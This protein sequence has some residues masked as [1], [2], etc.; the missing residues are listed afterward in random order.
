MQQRLAGLVRQEDVGQTVRRIAGLDCGY[1]GNTCV[2]GAVVW[3]I[4]L[5]RS[6]EEA[7]AEVEVDFPYVPGLLSF[8]ELPGLM[9]AYNKL[10]TPVDLLICDGQ[11]YAHPRRFGLACHLGVLLGIPTVGCA[12]RALVG[13]YEPPGAKRGV[14]SLI[15]DGSE[16]L[17]AAVRTRTGVRPVFISVGHLVTLDTACTVVLRCAP[18]YR[19]PEPTRRAD[20]LVSRVR[21]AS[22]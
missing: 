1:R 2:A 19:V 22:T 17:G 4:E 6:V 5:E 8:R 13:R 20:R 12:K 14:R 16:L 15:R 7:T 3:D 10:Q 21:Q 9:A 18:R 11:G